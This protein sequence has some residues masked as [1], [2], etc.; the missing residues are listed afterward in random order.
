MSVLRSIDLRRIRCFTDQRIEATPGINLMMGANGTGKTTAL[1]AVFAMVHGATFRHGRLQDMIQK[2]QPAGKIKL[3]LDRDHGAPQEHTMEIH[4]TSKKYAIN[5]ER[6]TAADQRTNTVVVLAPQHHKII[7]GNKTDRQK[8]LDDVLAQTQSEHRATLKHH[9]K[10]LNQQRALFKQDL[11]LQGYQEY[12]RPWLAQNKLLTERIRNAR[13]LLVQSLLPHL[14]Q[15]AYGISDGKSQ[16]ALIYQEKNEGLSDDQLLARE[17]YARRILYGAQRDDLCLTH[18][19]RSVDLFASQGEQATFLLAL[20][21]AE[22]ACLEKENK[23]PILL[24]DDLGTTLDQRRRQQLLEII[25]TKSTQTLITSCD[26][27]LSQ[28][29]QKSSQNMHEI[30]LGP[31]L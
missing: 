26:P 31:S 13:N 23:R 4:S 9:A 15:N 25:E 2:N 30:R 6:A 11:S 22:M 16:I 5:G 24:L 7:T 27:S 20:K 8:F 17:F 10:T 21:L 19:E 28:E 18:N 29:L 1:E 12:A 14:S 3:V